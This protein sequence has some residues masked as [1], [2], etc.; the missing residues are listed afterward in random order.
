MPRCPEIIVSILKRHNLSDADGR[1]LCKYRCSEIEYENIQAELR[2]IIRFRNGHLNGSTL[3]VAAFCLYA[4]EWWRKNYDSGHWTWNGILVS[5]GLDADYNRI[6]LYEPVRKGLKF[7]KRGLLTVG[8]RNAYFITLACEGGL[9]LKIIHREGYN[10]LQQYLKALLNEFRVYGR[11]EI[12]SF[13]LAGRIGS[14]LPMGLR[15]KPLFQ[16]CG[17]LIE[18][19]WNLQHSIG[20]TST[21]IEDLDRTQPS[22]RENFPLVVSDEAAKALLNSLIKDA[23]KIARIQEIKISTILKRIGTTYRLERKIQIPPSF[24]APSLAAQLQIPVHQLPYNVQLYLCQQSAPRQ[25][26]ALVTRR[27]A[28]D[29]GRFAAEIPGGAPNTIT[30]ISA[31]EQLWLDARSNNITREIRNIKGSL[32]LSELPWVFSAKDSNADQ[33]EL[34]GEGGLRTRHPFV[35]VA[36]PSTSN[37]ISSDD[38]CEY[39]GEDS[40]LG[41]QLYHIS[42]TVVVSDGTS[43]TTICTK[44]VE[45]DSAQYAMSGDFL[46]HGTFGSNIYKGIPKILSYLENG[47]IQIIPEAQLQWR[48]RR[49]S[50]AWK[51]DLL[52]CCGPVAI[53][54]VRQGE[55]HFMTNI[56]VVPRDGKI[57][58]IPG[59]NA[60]EGAIEI[61]GMAAMQYG[62]TTN[63]AGLQITTTTFPEGVRFECIAANDPPANLDVHIRWHLGQELA[64]SVP[65]PARGVRFINRDG[66]VLHNDEIIHM[67]RMAGVTVQVMDLD[68]TLTFSIEATALSN[69]LPGLKLDSIRLEEV[70]PGRHEIDLRQLQDGCNLLFSAVEDLDAMIKIGVI[71]NKFTTF[72]Q[73]IYVA[74]YDLNIKPDRDAGE[75]YIPENELETL[76]GDA[77]RLEF[78]AFPLANPDQEH[79]VLPATSSGRWQF[80][81]EDRAL[82][83]WLITGWDGDWSRI[84][85][86][87]WTVYDDSMSAPY[88]ATDKSFDSVVRLVA[89]RDR[90]DACD[91]LL[92]RLSADPNHNDW[93][94][95]NACFNHLKHLPATTFDV[96]GRLARHPDAAATA[97][98]KAGEDTFDEVWTGLERLPFAWYL[99]PVSSWMKAV[100]L[101]ERSL[102]ETLAPLAESFGG[103][104]DTVIESSFRTFLNQVPIRQ[105]GM[106]TLVEL[107]RHKLFSTPITNLPC[108]NMFTNSPF[109]IMRGLIVTPAEQDLL[110][111]HADDIWPT[112]PELEEEWWPTI[113]GQI[114]ADLHALWNTSIMGAGFRLS[115]LNAPVAAAYCATFNI[116]LKKRMVFN[117]RKLREFD[118]TWFDVAYGY[119]LASSIGYCIRND[120]EL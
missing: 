91:E 60:R 88:D 59:R 1:M 15:Q 118:P 62:C 5:L 41:R 97:I 13:E 74:R 76:N 44:A 78:R 77:S 73:R 28:G 112:C 102:R 100:K 63:H 109:Q 85:P 80:H 47:A 8:D 120:R 89:Q 39:L 3:E 6:D 92:G 104:L 53:R 52:T 96:I 26:L 37:I 90:S 95:I 9:P 82:G 54:H 79:E 50:D 83:P 43:N 17:E 117:I 71:S 46:S 105:P 68:P 94:N 34:I 98:L 51:S 31:V 106:Q 36:I 99:V 35:V 11:G 67:T 69:R 61:T 58:F 114:P 7:W 16:L 25:L 64:L 111:M 23:V 93:K 33:W 84:R 30:G 86:L 110:Q 45:E 22:W 27:T 87:C 81:R 103:N 40:Q 115:V 21:P 42:G 24:D 55:T 70:A 14:R 4:S 48:T 2:D 20:D 116:K 12:S 119:A 75:V 57:T 29:D 56:D 113:Q 108:L 32:G 65:Y 72:P 18:Q 38:L 19:V 101:R 49:G 66:T 10:Y 107:T